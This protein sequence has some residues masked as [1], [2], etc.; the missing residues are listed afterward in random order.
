M[1][2]LLLV[3]F[4][5][6]AFTAP[7][8]SQTVVS[9]TIKDTNNVPYTN[10]TVT[11]FTANP[12]KYVITTGDG[13]N[14][15]TAGFFSMSLPTG[16]YT[17]VVAAAGV[18][19]PLGTG[20]QQ[21][22]TSSVVI[23]GS[24][25]NVSSTL[26]T[27]A[28]KLTSAAFP[29]GTS[30][31]PGAGGTPNAVLVD[32][33]TQGTCMDS[34][35]LSGGSPGTLSYNSIVLTWPSASGTFC[36][37]G[38]ICALFNGSTATTQSAADNSTKLATTAYVDRVAPSPAVQTVQVTVTSMQLLHMVASPVTIIAAP[39][40]GKSVHV[41]QV[42][43][44]NV[45]GSTPYTAPDPVMDQIILYYP[46]NLTDIITNG[47]TYQIYQSGSVVG[48]GCGNDG[49]FD[50]GTL[51][52]GLDIYLG[53]SKSNGM[54]SALRSD[55]DDQPVL[56]TMYNTTTQMAASGELSLGNGTA[57]IIVTYVVVPD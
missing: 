8:F 10:A 47:F 46:P 22:T 18:Q 33:G 34:S 14:G 3:A 49:C 13:T 40:S 26:N 38:A 52:A 57:N 53:Y 42:T 48:G 39:G 56:M 27:N 9:G 24:T 44:E 1:R 51:A 4:L 23:S 37:S 21:F 19:P 25:Q 30:N 15:S 20:A 12:Q 41:L 17:F 29:S 6:G 31:C 45:P 16:T 5:L 7:A 32:S 11:A 54:Y 55:S 43:A 2:K 28:P 50:P 35:V 36:A